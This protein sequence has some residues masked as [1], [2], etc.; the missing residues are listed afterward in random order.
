MA[1][2]GDMFIAGT[3]NIDGKY[4]SGIAFPLSKKSPLSCVQEIAPGSW[5][6]ELRKDSDDIIARSTDKLD[7]EALQ[8]SGFEAV[9]I[10]LDILSAKGIF[11]AYV[12]H[13]ATTN[14]GVYWVNSRSV[15]Y[16]QS[17]FDFPMGVSFQVQQ[18]DASGIK[19]KSPPPAEPIW[20]ES[21]RFYRLSQS[22][23]DLFEAY[24]N[25]FL[26][27]EALLNN[28]CAKNRREGEAA[29]LRRALSVVNSKMSLSQFAPS[30]NADPIEYIINSQYINVRCKLQHAKFPAAELPHSS[31]N[32]VTVKQA[33]SELVRIWRQIAGAYLNV[34]TGGGVITYAGFEDVIGKAFKDGAAM[35]YTSDNLPPR[36]EDT[37]VSPR[38]FPVHEFVVSSYK[39][40]VRPGVVRLI[41][42]EDTLELAE[43]YDKPIHRVCSKVGTALFG[44]AYIERGLVVTG[45]DQW[46]CIQDFRLINTAQPNIEFDT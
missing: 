40:Q 39:G 20:N 28:I 26:S 9:Q 33:Y 46:E 22:S 15:V 29:W 19:I 44:V 30:G 5:Q 42:Q 10:A 16:L 14:I 34:P 35:L 45:V 13:P 32:P 2:L 8:S 31:L 41:G 27:F 25:L 4:K 37:A 18:F 12:V 7:Q 6:V 24:R 23:N 43:N 38:S 21:F 36:N 17:L 3:E 11:S 1:F